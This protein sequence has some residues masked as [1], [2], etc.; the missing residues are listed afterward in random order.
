MKTRLIQLITDGFEALYEIDNLIQ[1]TYIKVL[2][3]EYQETDYE[4]FED[5]LNEKHPLL[6]WKRVF[7][8]EIYI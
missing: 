6:V 5:F 4:D 7:V 1:D 2:W 3:N 8:D